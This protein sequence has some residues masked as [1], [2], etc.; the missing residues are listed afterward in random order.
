MRKFYLLIIFV[1][2]AHYLFLLSIDFLYSGLYLLQTIRGFCV[3]RRI[4]N[5]LLHLAL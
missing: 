4:G 3:V 5:S 1:Y 2:G